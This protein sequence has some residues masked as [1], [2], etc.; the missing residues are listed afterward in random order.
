MLTHEENVEAHALR[1]RGWSIAAI[2]RH[3]GRDRKTI[4]AYMRGERTPGVRR[5]GAPD[6]FLPYEAYVRARLEEDPHLWGTALYDELRALGHARSN[7]TLTRELRR[8]G[9]RPRCLSC[10]ASTKRAT[11]EID[12]PP[13]RRSSGTGSIFPT[14]PVAGRRTFSSAR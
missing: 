12:H 5:A 8:R 11:I 9:L 6:A 10:L 7:P 3:M 1:R 2:A 4:R 14:P 13:A